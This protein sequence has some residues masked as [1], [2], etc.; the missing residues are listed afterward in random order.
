MSNDNNTADKK[1]AKERTVKKKAA[2]NIVVSPVNLKSTGSRSSKEVTAPIGLV[3]N[4]DTAQPAPRPVQKKASAPQQRPV[5]TGTGW[6]DRPPVPKVTR[7]EPIKYKAVPSKKS[8]AGQEASVI[9]SP[10]KD[11]AIQQEPVRKPE[12]V[13]KKEPEIKKETV[14]NPD[15]GKQAEIT[16]KPEQAGNTEPV[17]RTDPDINKPAPT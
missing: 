8:A 5:I 17:L 10:V 6:P 9:N 2:R 15:P 14:K 1:I 4:E 3:W 16:E 12:K 11:E 7:P 13:K